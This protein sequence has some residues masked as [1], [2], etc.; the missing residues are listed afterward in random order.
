MTY[1]TTADIET[2]EQN[3]DST[4]AIVTPAPSA[5]PLYSPW[6]PSL[7]EDKERGKRTWVSPGGRLDKVWAQ[8]G[9]WLG[10]LA[11][12][13][14][15]GFTLLLAKDEPVRTFTVPVELPAG[16]PGPAAGPTELDHRL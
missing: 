6:V 11:I 3:E 13:V 4:G 7:D 8:R 14:S 2:P 1:K 10:L 12:A 5:Q 15:F 9:L 16:R